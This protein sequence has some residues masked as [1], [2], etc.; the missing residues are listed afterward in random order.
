[1]N[2]KNRN[3]ENGQAIVYLALGIIVFLGFVALAIDG[4]MV[5]ADRRNTQNAADAAS[6][7]GGGAA[8][9]H[10]D[11]NKKISCDTQWTCDNYS[12]ITNAEID[13]RQ[14]AIDR[15]SANGFDIERDDDLAD[16]NGVKTTCGGTN[17]DNG[18]IDVTVAIS[19]TTPSNFLQLVFPNAL[20]NE[21]DAVT[22]VHPGGPYLFGNAIVALN[23]ENCSDPGKQGVIVGGSGT[24]KVT[25]GDVFSNG[26]VRQDSP[27]SVTIDPP[28][29]AEGHSLFK[30]DSWAST[31]TDSIPPSE[32]DL[33]QPDC[34]TAPAGHN[35]DT[36]TPGYKFPKTLGDGLWCVTG[37]V[38]INQADTLEGDGVTIVMLTGKFFIN[39]PADV[40][41]Y[42]PS[43]DH[44][45]DTK[46][47]ENGMLI[48]LPKSNAN[49]VSMDGNQT[50]TF[51][52]LV[53]APSS[54]ITMSGTGTNIYNDSQVVGY[55]VVIQGTGDLTLTYKGCNGYLRSPSIELYK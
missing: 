41:L 35:I 47:A 32:Y 2:S 6:L 39:G 5:L 7:A 20:H 33:E 17:W 23:P 44:P 21:V 40:H 54:K 15:A 12:V 11:N 26:C 13:A 36:T 53:Y 29:I 22:R 1:M 37:D 51:E 49:D 46:T 42:A 45:D 28:Y 4:G 43:V 38:S 18:Y 19:A 16:H 24:L 34:S 8:A 10:L 27:V 48:Y 55:N 25:G 14:A 30:S 31:T 52:G 9:F 3:S 50:S